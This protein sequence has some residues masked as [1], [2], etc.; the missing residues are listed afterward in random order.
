M[1]AACAPGATGGGG[2]G[3][4]PTVRT[5]L[6][7]ASA[8]RHKALVAEGDAAWLERKDEAKLREALG[9]WEQA[10]AIKADDWDTCAK[11]ARGFYFLGDGYLSFT[12]EGNEAGLKAMLDAYEKAFTYAERGMK[13][14]S[15]EFEK[16]LALGSTHE[17]AINVL[18]RQ[19]VPLM[20][21]YDA[22]LGKWAKA[23]DISVTLKYKDRLFA[24]M[25]Q[26][27]T[28][29]P[30]YFYGAAE[31]YFGGYY[32][33]APTF[34]G[35]DLNKSR[36]YFEKSLKRA[37]NALSTHVLIAE[38]LA[39]KL[40]DKALFDRELKFVMDTPANVIPELEAEA[41]R[42]KA[43]AEALMKKADELF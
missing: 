5:P 12:A 3:S 14:Y 33:V 43:K 22:A 25:S 9:K 7:A 32:A 36:E 13:A 11:L 8:D 15:P 26:I 24:I 35:G 27:Y 31:R 30:D 10:M 2:G 41:L 20:Y 1:V 34:A 21:W 6:D 17:A 28:L 19:A 42:E 18:D 40:Q 16:K 29:D 23:Q 39:P 4:G 38:L 37:P